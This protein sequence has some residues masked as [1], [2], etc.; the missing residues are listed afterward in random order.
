MAHADGKQIQKTF[1][2]LV[3]DR[4]LLEQYWTE[5][6]EYSYPVRGESFS[7]KNGDPSSVALTAKKKQSKIYDSTATDSVRLLASSLL[8]G[9]TP[10]HS[11]WF[12][13]DIP[14]VPDNMIPRDAKQ[15]LQFAAETLFSTIHGSNYNSEAFELFIDLTIGGM[16][17][18]FVDFDEDGFKF[19]HWPL[20]SLYCQDLL[21]HNRI[22][23]IYR[24]VVM[25]TREA[26]EKFGEANV[27]E[28]VIEAF[29][30]DPW[31]SKKHAF[32]H[33][34]RPRL[35]NGKQSRGKLKQNMPWESV[36]VC[37]K[38][39]EIVEESGFQEMPV[40]VPRW[41]GIP[42]TDYALGPLN[43]ALP[44]VK[45]LN[46]VV[47]MILTNGEMAIA[48]TFVAKDDGV[49]NPN[50][51]RIGPRRVIMVAEP[52]NIKP[53]ASGGNFNIAQAEIT[54]LQSQ[55]KRVMMSD[56]LAP[57]ERG[58]MTATE[59]TTRTQI[60]RQIL[61]PAL[62]RLQ[63]EFLEP[64]LNR[65]FGLAMRAGILGQPPESMAGLVFI[66][67]Y[68][69][70]IAKAQK[71]EMVQAMDQLEMSLTAM[72]QLDPEIVDLYDLEASLKKR[73]DLLG[74][75]IECLKDERAVQ[76]IRQ[77]RAQA[78]DQRNAQAQIPQLA[79]AMKNVGQSGDVGQD[80]LMA[81]MGAVSG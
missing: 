9:L 50:T 40:V 80:A 73:A 65:C 11:Q 23:T 28:E 4:L 42:G 31:C 68:H 7:N 62:A 75:P 38:T 16:C 47:E 44:D 17:G 2:R 21:G 77:A 15:W 64:L 24:K 60:I 57:T 22:D 53:L 30:Q 5:A 33:T 35:N 55:I 52:D 32:I 46:R 26:I 14:N 79:S 59:V 37:A 56:Q 61:S 45:T 36:Y 12:S 25:T 6:F 48:G 72:K 58:N 20:H 76:M 71:M 18:I 66:P 29:R 51:V 41:F 78:Q 3:N 27:P 19:E 39:G 13:L 74:V 43:E 63:S 67:T 10:S 1:E 49:F 70:P 81:M 69:S 8:S 54:R 34:I